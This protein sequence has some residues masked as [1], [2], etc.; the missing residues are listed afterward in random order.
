M[1]RII[2]P[3]HNPAKKYRR[4]SQTEALRYLLVTRDKH[5][6]RL[7]IMEGHI[8]DDRI[9]DDPC[10]E[11]RDEYSVKERQSGVFTNPFP[12]RKEMVNGCRIA[13]PRL[14]RRRIRVAPYL[15]KIQSGDL[16]MISEDG[17]QNLDCRPA[18]W[19]SARRHGELT[20]QPPVAQCPA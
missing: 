4:V 18:H 15:K 9:C 2:T 13:N 11:A 16:R 8:V 6:G 1:G 3:H 10:A 20:P 14:Q 19:Y 5:R 7:W 17:T 12:R